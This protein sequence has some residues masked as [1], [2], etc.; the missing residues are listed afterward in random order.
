M[1][2]IYH[3]LKLINSAWWYELRERQHEI[4]KHWQKYGRS[5]A[6]ERARRR[7]QMLKNRDPA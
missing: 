2:R 1:K 4:T 6:N 5:R 7:R 3:H